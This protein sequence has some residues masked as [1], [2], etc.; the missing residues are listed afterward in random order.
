MAER[1]EARIAA[2][3]ASIDRLLVDGSY[4]G[5]MSALA[6]DRDR[7]AERIALVER[8]PKRE[9]DPDDAE[10]RSAALV[11]K[12]YMDALVTVRALLY[13]PPFD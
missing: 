7:L 12:G 8:L 13:L 6:A 11:A 3:K 4:A 1:Y 10:A 2:Q 9:W 5:E